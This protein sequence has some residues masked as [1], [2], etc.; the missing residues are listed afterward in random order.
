MNRLLLSLGLAAA[1]LLTGC[2]ICDPVDEVVDDFADRC[3]DGPCGWTADTGAISQVPTI[4]ESEL[5]MRLERDTTASTSYRPTFFGSREPEALE[6]TA[7]CDPGT[8]LR[9]SIAGTDVAVAADGGTVDGRFRRSVIVNDP[10]TELFQVYRTSFS[11]PV[12][13][14]ADTAEVETMGEGGCV[15]DD[16]VLT[17][18][19]GC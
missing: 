3:A 16:I 5:G 10:D 12:G 19:P 7:R 14:N 17:S 1:T 13:A 11:W 18:Q 8:M 15:V 9:V 2:P 6:V 4:H